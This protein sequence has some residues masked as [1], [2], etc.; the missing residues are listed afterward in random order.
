VQEHLIA[1]HPEKFAWITLP[2]MGSPKQE[3][4]TSTDG[5]KVNN[6]YIFQ[7]ICAICALGNT[8]FSVFFF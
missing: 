3:V 6:P 1:V 2:G 8:D 7:G 4:N 5:L